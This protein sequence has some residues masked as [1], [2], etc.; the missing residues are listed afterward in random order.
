MEWQFFWR[1]LFSKRAGSVVRRVSWL[2]IMAL[3]VSLTALILVIS[4]MTALNLNMQD[5]LLA[6]E[7][8]VVIEFQQDATGVNWA[9]TMNE[10]ERRKA[11]D[12][13]WRAYPFES[14]DV[15]LRT[16]EGR[17]RGAQAR[18]LTLP[19]LD[20]ISAEVQRIHR[21]QTGPENSAK[22]KVERAEKSDKAKDA[23]NAVATG[24]VLR[25]RDRLEGGEVLLGVDLAYMLGVFEGDVVTV[26]APE[27][28]LLPS[29]ETPKFE[30]IRVREIL[31][32]NIQDFD[33]Q[34]VFY[35]QGKTLSSFS[36]SAS[37]RRGLEI[38]FPSVDQ[39][40]EGKERLVRTIADLPVK[41]STWRER[42]SALFLSLRLE[43]VV[44]TMFLSIAATI[45]GF[46][47]IIVMGLL[48]S[49]KRREIGLL[50]AIGISRLRV[51]R[52]FQGLSLR[53]AAFGMGVGALL[54]AGISLYMEHHPLKL[55]PPDTYYDADVPAHVD[56]R[57]VVVVLLVGFL[58]AGVGGRLV[59]R[60]L[61]KL[62]PTDLLKT[63]K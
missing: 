23:G 19:A 39:V 53:L 29:G 42:N 45:A 51:F 15:I 3:T 28:L 16:A 60:P 41:I 12:P 27:G 32:T 46:S 55:L 2:S 6:V 49:E 48:I 50:Q 26:I 57:F 33:S 52:L 20:F 30:K 18:G 36:R 25:E 22:I 11:L 5:R 58:L 14:Q 21:H 62:L 35:L 13:S 44:I 4:V 40:D 34:G 61:A 24:S 56:G 54:G 37:L 1:F 47:L 9:Q 38:W 31:S 17:F 8:H 7:P 43:K 10:I 59:S 63:Q